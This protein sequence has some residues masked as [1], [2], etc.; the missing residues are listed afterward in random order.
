[1]IDFDALIDNHLVRK[2]RAKTIGRYYPS[3]AGG[4]LRKTWFSYKIPKQVDAETQRVFEA[5]NMLHEFITEVIKSEKN[6]DIE[7]LKSEMPIKIET[8]DFIISGR[9][10]NLV[11]VK[12]NNKQVL[13]EVKSTKFLPEEKRAEHEM[14][15]QL[16]MQ[17]TDV[18]DGIILYIQK[19]NLQTK[20]FHIKHNKEMS[21]K[22][23]E[24]F[25]IIH[26]SLTS[27]TMPQPEAKLIEDK[28]WLCNYCN[29]RE[30]CDEEEGLGGE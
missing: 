30:E 2:F 18:S 4:C 21:D 12:I 20:T 15:L 8:N 29:W 16:Y 9:I 24:R 22:I 3:E 27:N 25:R 10:D 7:L 26:N 23:I 13:V 14:Q 19:D 1:M 28:A 6:Q 5:G 11:L 17:A